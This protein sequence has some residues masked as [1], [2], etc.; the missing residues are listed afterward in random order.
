MKIYELLS[1]A[2]MALL[3]SAAPLAAEETAVV[4]GSRINVRGRPALIGEVITQLQQG[5]KVVILEEITLSSPA[6]NE[7]S[8]WLRIQMP[9]QTPVWVYAPFVDQA[10]KTVKV[11]RLNLRGGPGEN[12]SVVGRLERG[13]S[14]R[15]I[16]RVEDW[17][18]VETPPG[19]YAFIAADL[20]TK[21]G[22]L[23]AAPG[24]GAQPLPPITPPADRADRVQSTQPAVAV[25]PQTPPAQ[26]PTPST[27]PVTRQQPPAIAATPAAGEWQP[28]RPKSSPA[29]AIPGEQK[30]PAAAPLPLPAADGWQPA[31]QQTGS[32]TVSSTVPGP[33]AP[34]AT[35]PAPSNAA[36]PKPS[37]PQLSERASSP[38]PAATESSSRR[39]V[40]REGLVRS[41]VSIQ[42][43]T[44]YELLSPA[45][46]KT[47]NY[48]H[49]EKLGL[50]LKDYR[51]RQ[52]VVTG[53]EAI[54]PRW[55]RIPVIEVE[56]LE[57][58]P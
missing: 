44:Y 54:D 38:T 31:R 53:E 34:A 16:R 41:T 20:V 26:S 43:P 30:N 27:P 45:N 29:V 3:L 51:G 28:V 52:I 56:T 40:R 50:D 48:L 24:S 25:A 14:V 13:A 4:K 39:I 57:L 55:P 21:T 37:L 11:S 58:I 2:G 1:W 10:T 46:R 18:E 12:F 42:A 8:K 5:E 17:M 22:G 6:T 47:I 35:L 15:E 36:S 19:A 49:T 23:A 9:A 32:S 7:P 33:T